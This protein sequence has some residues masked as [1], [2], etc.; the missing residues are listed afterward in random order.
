MLPI[1]KLF[2]LPGK[3]DSTSLTVSFWLGDISS[4][5]SF[6]LGLIVASEL[7]ILQGEH[8][9]EW[10]EVVLIWEFGP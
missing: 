6:G 8:P 10:K 7:G 2:Y 1:F 4:G 3:K 9:C 5:L